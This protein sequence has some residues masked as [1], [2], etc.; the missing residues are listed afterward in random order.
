MK[1]KKQKQPLHLLPFYFRNIGLGLL[2]LLLFSLLLNISVWKDLE[3]KTEYRTFFE[4]VLLV[5]LLIITI[6]KG[7]I[8]DERTIIIR[9]QAYAAT[10]IMGVVSFII[11]KV[12]S[13]GSGNSISAF[14]LI[15]NMFIFY[16]FIFWWM[17]RKR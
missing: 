5:A 12:L 13:F 17:K 10:L 7:R 6:S 3:W 15:L 11:G 4:I 1:K 14:N 9:L 16:F 8:E 2:G